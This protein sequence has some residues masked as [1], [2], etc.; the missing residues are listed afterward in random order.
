MVSRVERNGR[1]WRVHAG[2]TIYETEFVIWSAPTWLA[3]WTVDP[4]PP[5]L[6]ME[7]VP[8]MVANLTL[9]RWPKEKG[10][11][12]AWDNVIYGS[13]SLGYVVATHQSLKTHIPRT[14]WTFY[15]ALSEG[16]AADQRRILLGGD[17][18][19]W[20]D[21]IF[22]DL[23]R[24]HPDIRSCVSRVDIFRIG[25]AMPRPAPGFLTH[26]DRLALCK[27]KGTLVFANTDLSGLSLFEEAQYRGIEAARH[28]LS[29][30]GGRRVPERD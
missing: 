29:V 9:D 20:C 28:A 23:E 22:A 8:W 17:W 24:P 30:A 15:W 3:R 11:P 21:K 1:G 5:A 6:P 18:K 14:V 7:S 25:H 16:R 27:H 19:Y 12:P 26:P 10:L 13:P 4:P 2:E